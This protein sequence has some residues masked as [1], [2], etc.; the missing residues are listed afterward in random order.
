MFTELS[1]HIIGAVSSIVCFIVAVV[2]INLIN[3]E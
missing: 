3:K 1:P 2:I